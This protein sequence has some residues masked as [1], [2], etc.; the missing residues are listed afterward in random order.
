VKEITLP[1]NYDKSSPDIRRLAREKYVIE[2]DGLCYYCKS[3]LR[4]GPSSEVSSVKVNR[5]FFPKGF[6]NYPIHLHHNHDT[7]MTIGAVHNHCN[8]VLWQYHG[9]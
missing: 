4:S 1:I 6:F 9:E 2:Q 8:A 3:K 7:G 5:H